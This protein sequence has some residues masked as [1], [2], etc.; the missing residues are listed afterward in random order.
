M[1]DVHLILCYESRERNGEL[2]KQ[3]SKEVANADIKQQLRKVGSTFLT[4][5]EVSA[6]ECAYF[7][8]MLV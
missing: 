2:P 1:C 6:Q 7:E 4:H 3:A 5:S 8:T